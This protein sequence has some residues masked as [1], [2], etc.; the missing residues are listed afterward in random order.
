M[1]VLETCKE[2][3]QHEDSRMIPVAKDFFH[4]H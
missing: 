4:L 1:Q 3:C 2:T